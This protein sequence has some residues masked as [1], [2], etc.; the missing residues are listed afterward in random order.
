MSIVEKNRNE[1]NDLPDADKQKINAHEK[2]VRA[3]VA[4]S[5]VNMNVSSSDMSKVFNAHKSGINQG[6]IVNDFKN[7]VNNALRNLMKTKINL[8]IDNRDIKGGGPKGSKLKQLLQILLAI[9]KLPKRFLFLSKSLAEATAGFTISIDGF[10]KSVALGAKDIYAIIIA[11]ANIIIKYWLCWISFTLTT[12]FAGCLFVH[13]ITLFVALVYWGANA[14]IRYF[15]N[16]YNFKIIE[17]DDSI[18]WMK[19]MEPINTV[20]YTCFGKKVKARDVLTDVQ[21]IE[22]L[23]NTLNY[24]FN[25]RMPRY[26]KRGAPL[27]RAALKSLNT[28]VN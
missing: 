1:Y 23:G 17:V 13:I 7:A 24:D 16:K 14:V 5:G 11:I 21:V 9:V 20:C 18:E 3:A 27:G 2:D 25:T 15:Q 26:M 10:A 8:N 19:W 4:L 22:K 6:Q 28:A 12:F